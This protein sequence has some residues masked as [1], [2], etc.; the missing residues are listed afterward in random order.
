[1][2]DSTVSFYAFLASIAIVGGFLQNC[3]PS[4]TSA[5]S[6]LQVAKLPHDVLVG[7][8]AIASL[9]ND[10]V[11]NVKRPRLISWAFFELKTRF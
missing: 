10:F 8:E 6:T 2:A 9:K 3:S 7:I 11:I 1:M 4:H 5:R